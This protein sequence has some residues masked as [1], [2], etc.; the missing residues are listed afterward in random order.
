MGAGRS[1]F[2]PRFLR[3]EASLNRT[4]IPDDDRFPNDLRRANGLDLLGA[5]S[6]GVLGTDASGVDEAARRIAALLAAL[7]VDDSDDG[8][9]VDPTPWRLDYLAHWREVDLVW[10]GGGSVARFGHALATA[11]DR[12]L[13]SFGSDLRVRV[14]DQPTLLP[15]IGAAR[16]LVGEHRAAV[17]L[18]FG[19]TSVKRALVR[20]APDGTLTELDVLEPVGVDLSVSDGQEILRFL[21]RVI[22]DTAVECPAAGAVRASIAASLTSAGIATDSR[23]YYAAIGTSPLPPNATFVHDGTAA[24]LAVEPANMVAVVT[25]GTGIG[26]GFGND[27]PRRPLSKHFSVHS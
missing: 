15:L 9:G 4:T 13:A 8:L 14:H 7:V 5:H 1:D 2:D 18:D 21:E 26:I 11:T 12:A 25:L 27:E 17:V 24:A 10:L 16:T 23:S 3:A 20:Y 6:L 19:H 22:G